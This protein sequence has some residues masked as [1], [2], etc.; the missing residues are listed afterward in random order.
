MPEIA[1]VF[2]ALLTVGLLGLAA[3]LLTPH[4]MTAVGLWT[5]LLGL[6]SG[7][8]TGFWY[9]VVLY[10]FLSKKIVMP[11]RWWWSPVDLHPH[12]TQEELAGIKPWF[13]L[14][15]IG[16]LLSLAGGL[17]AMAGLLLDH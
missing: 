1:L 3:T 12:L 7:I 2:L 11:A 9:H 13:F 4:L 6:V 16:F 8:P 15:G 10:R 17:A 14:G 5:L